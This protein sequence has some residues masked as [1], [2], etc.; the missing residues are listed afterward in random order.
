MAK[1]YV[2]SKRS[3]IFK[4][5]KQDKWGHKAFEVLGDYTE[6]I[7]VFFN[8]EQARARRDNVI[9]SYVK[10]GQFEVHWKLRNGQEINDVFKIDLLGCEK[11]AKYGRYPY[12]EIYAYPISES[13]L[14][15]N[16]KRYYD[17]SMFCS[18]TIRLE[19]K[20]DDEG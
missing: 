16:E 1:Y 19:E 13:I 2:L 7:G 17:A 11:C 4:M 12:A 18:I 14:S 3:T 15:L 20:G 5:H 8:G 6:N 9:G 10:Q